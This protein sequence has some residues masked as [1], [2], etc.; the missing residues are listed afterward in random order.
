MSETPP[1]SFSGTYTLYHKPDGG[2]HIAYLVDGD[3]ETK[4]LDLPGALMQA[5]RMA[6]ENGMNPLSLLKMVKN[7][8]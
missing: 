1:E 4:H 3:E 2:I 8:H 6:A 5:A 7:L